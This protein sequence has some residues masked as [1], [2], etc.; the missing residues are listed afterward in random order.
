MILT[1]PQIDSLLTVHIALAKATREELGFDPTI[2]QVKSKEGDKFCITVK[3]QDIKN[4][5]ISEEWET[6]KWLSNS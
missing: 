5:P 6:V 1:R 2:T 4:R 3:G